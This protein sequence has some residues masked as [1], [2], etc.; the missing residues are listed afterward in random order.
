MTDPMQEDQGPDEAPEQ[1]PTPDAPTPDQSP[2]P[3]GEAYHTLGALRYQQDQAKQA[4]EQQISQIAE[5]GRD[6]EKQL[7]EAEQLNDGEAVQRITEAIEEL[8]KAYAL[9]ADEL[10]QH[11][12]E[13]VEDDEEDEGEP[14]EGE[15]DQPQ[16]AQDA[17]V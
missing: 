12:P 5:K 11:Q 1:P 8:H 10:E 16:E 3:Q 13:Q 14:D 15:D 4:L 7:E 2:D 17:E 9:A 6:L